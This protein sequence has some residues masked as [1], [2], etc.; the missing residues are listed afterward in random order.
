MASDMSQYVIVDDPRECVSLCNEAA[1][2]ERAAMHLDMQGHADAAAEGYRGAAA[3]M[4]DAA[5]ACPEGHPD[6]RLLKLHACELL[7][8]ADYLDAAG[9]AGAAAV[10]LERH[11]HAVQLSLG[12][13]ELLADDWAAAAPWY[14]LEQA[15]VMGAAA[16]LGAATGFLVLGPITGVVLGAATAA[17]ATREDEAGRAARRVGGAGARALD[18]VLRLD[19]EHRV[20]RRVT[21][22][23][24]D[25]VERTVMKSRAWLKIIDLA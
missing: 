19:R 10:P 13:P 17:A 22:A 5:A 21:A 6:C 8:R 16:A 24:R 18:R 23:G 7:R 14:S 11:I 20:S 12:L 15:K 1:A 9:C 2:T 25:I 4:H 3:K